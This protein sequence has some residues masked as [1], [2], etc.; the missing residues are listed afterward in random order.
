MFTDNILYLITNTNLLRLFS[1]IIGTCENHMKHINTCVKSV[2]FLLQQ[3]VNMELNYSTS[4]IF[5]H[6]GM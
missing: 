5:C 6:P 1:D 2:K 3:L 4:I